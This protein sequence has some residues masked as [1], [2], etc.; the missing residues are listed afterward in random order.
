MSASSARPPL[1]CVILP[2]V[3]ICGGT[4]L[5]S[6]SISNWASIQDAIRIA[7]TFGGIQWMPA[8][9]AL[10]AAS[11]FASCHCATDPAPGKEREISGGMMVAMCVSWLIG[12][13]AFIFT[14]GDM[15][16]I[17]VFQGTAAVISGLVLFMPFYFRFLEHMAR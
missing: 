7:I 14:V 6:A 15:N 17:T 4:A 2:F 11:A 9:I 16:T 5:L 1:K 12:A 10:V 8:V 13:I 3:A